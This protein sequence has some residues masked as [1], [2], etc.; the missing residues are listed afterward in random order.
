MIRRMLRIVLIVLAILSWP[1]P[2]PRAASSPIKRSSSAIAI[3]PDG[4]ILLVANPDSNSVSLL[5]A[6][7]LS[8]LGEVPVGVDPRT[9]AIDDAGLR[10]YVACRGSDSVAAIDLASRQVVAQATVG[11]RPYGVVVD[12]SGGRVYL[13][14]QARDQVR[15]LDAGTLATRAVIP[16]LDMPSGLAVSADGRRLYVAH[17]LTSHISVIQVRLHN[18]LLPLLVRGGSGHGAAPPGNLRSDY[19]TSSIALWPD[20]NLVQSIVLSPD[21]RRGYVPHTRSNS[22]NRALTF[23]T[24]VFPLVSLLDLEAGTQMTGKQ[25]DL[26]TVDPPGVGLPFDAAL[27]PDGGVLWVANAA[28][29]DV[30]VIDV[31]RSRLI[32]HVEVGDNP[33]GIV[34]SLDG[35]TAYV[36]N[37]LAGTVSAIDARTYRVV[38]TATATAIPLPP[39]LLTGKRL[40]H[41]SDD[42]RMSRA[43]WIACNTCHFDGEH[44]GQTWRFGFAGPRNTTSLLGMIQTYPLRWSGE[45]D[46]SADAEFAV[47]EESL[48]AGLIA[49]KMHCVA[50][51]ADCADQPPNQGRSNDLDCLAAYIDSLP[52]PLSPGHAHGEPLTDSER[53]GQGLFAEPALGCVGCH[54]PPL[55]TDLLAH[56]VGTATQ[57][58]RIGPAYDTPSLRGLWQSAPY[59]HDGSAATLRDALTRPSAGS[60]HDVTGLLTE[61]E[62]ADLIAYLL[63]LPFA[64]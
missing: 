25:I 35:R 4:Q 64:E 55:Y 45:W 18:V 60:E 15:V 34:L 48:G 49:G 12:P 13:A 59:F 30:S 19:P 63:A 9:V 2:P 3:T 40:F 20:S 56:D 28:S 17:L 57:D 54:P 31:A 14:E 39:I 42:P 26:G 32:A 41:T 11:V 22:A 52:V 50:S 29:N 21:G 8:L 24:T 47:R 5:A 10:A 16:T 33:R 6:G 43:Q 46:E 37:T 38:D 27:S 7:D 61:A 58:E 1:A 36:N 53:R 44:D 51:P 62:L 23:D